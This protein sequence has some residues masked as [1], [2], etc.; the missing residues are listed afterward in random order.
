MRWMYPFE[1]Y[2]KKLKNYIRNKN[3][4]EDSI[5]KG[6]I[7]DNALT[8]C[9]MYFEGVQTRFIRLNKKKILSFQEGHCLCLNHNVEHL[10][11]KPH[12]SGRRSL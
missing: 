8:F 11:K 7:V 9:S 2:M 6:Y 4:P 10:Q 1:R 3:K 12:I 5:A